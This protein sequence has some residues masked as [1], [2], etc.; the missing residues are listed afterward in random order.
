SAISMIVVRSLPS[1]YRAEAV[2][3]VDSQKIPENF[4]SPTVSGDLADRLALINQSIMSSARLLDI[5]KA[6][7]LYGKDRARLTQEELLRKMRDDISVNFEKSWT[8]DR[9]HAFRLGY[10]GPDPNV[11]AQVANRLAG[12][13]VLENV[14]AREDQAEGTVH[15]LARQLQEA[16]KS[17]D[18]Q[19][20]KLA[21]FKEEHNGTLPEQQSSLMGTLTSLG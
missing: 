12:L 11:V 19:E 17:L 5:I 2:V 9:M 15:F 20:Q 6:F 1:V 21:R 16:K 7:N 3:L 13:Y 8:G 14:R 18:E 10:Q 4:V